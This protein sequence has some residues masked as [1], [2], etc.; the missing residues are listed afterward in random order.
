MNGQETF[1]EISPLYNWDYPFP[2]KEFDKEVSYAQDSKNFLY[3]HA[4]VLLWSHFAFC[5]K[6][7]YI[8]SAGTHLVHSKPL[9]E[10]DRNQNED[11]KETELEQLCQKAIQAV[12]DG[13]KIYE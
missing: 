10:G 5:G 4:L 12:C 11:N 6:I 1:L 2:N 8:Q 3:D 13:T 7:L 9:F